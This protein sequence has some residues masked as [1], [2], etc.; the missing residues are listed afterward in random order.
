M[1]LLHQPSSW[2]SLEDDL[3]GHWSLDEGQGL[4]AADT[5]GFG[6]G[7]ALIKGPIWIK[8]RVGSSSIS[9]DGKDDVL[10]LDKD[11]SLSY[12]FSISVWMRADG[13]GVVSLS[14]PLSAAPYFNLGL[15]QGSVFMGFRPDTGTDNTQIT[16]PAPLEE[17]IHI[18]G[19]FASNTDKKLY[20]NGNLMATSQASKGF[21]AQATVFSIGR[22]RVISP[23]YMKGVV[24]EIRLYQRVLSEDEI[25]ELYQNPE[26]NPD[27]P[28]INIVSPTKSSAWPVPTNLT[29]TTNLLNPKN[30]AITK[31]E[32]FDGTTKIGEDTTA[33]YS[34]Q[35]NDVPE[36]AH[37]LTVKISSNDFISTS[38]AINIVVGKAIYKVSKDASGNFS[39]IQECL[40][41]AKAGTSCLVAPGH[42]VESLSFNPGMEGQLV[43]L[44]AEHPY[45]PLHPENSSIVEGGITLKNFTGL[46]GLEVL[47][48][49]VTVDGDSTEVVGNFIHGSGDISAGVGISFTKANPYHSNVLIKNNHIYQ[50][51]YGMLIYCGHDCLIEF[52]DIERLYTKLSCRPSGACEG[53]N[54]HVRIFGNGIIFRGNHIHGSRLDEID[55]DSHVDGI[56]S[57]TN[58]G[59][60]GQ[61]RDTLTNII[62]EN[63]LIQDAH[64][65]IWWT[66][67]TSSFNGV[68]MMSSNIIIRNNIFRNTWGTSARMAIGG[69]YADEIYV[70]NNVFGQ[71]VRIT[72]KN[73]SVIKNNVFFGNFMN[74]ANDRFYWPQLNYEMDRNIL[75]TANSWL[76]D[77]TIKAYPALV[78]SKQLIVGP[79]ETKTFINSAAG[80]YHLKTGS[81]AIDQGVDM[82]S[83]GSA[84]DKD[85]FNRGQAWDIGAYEYRDIMGDVSDD[86]RVTLHDAA[87]VFRYTMGAA[88]TDVQKAKADINGDGSVDTLDAISIARKALGL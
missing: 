30:V 50:V 4:I 72:A 5:S 76:N 55:E 37:F 24:D 22:N 81:L 84:L 16:A 79:D 18:V 48:A 29:V 13:N 66:S 85:D 62:I 44:E 69:T 38:P 3:I 67:D 75:Y 88:L 60:G 14:S 12:P 56:Q 34:Y 43:K 31:A 19:V 53:D 59:L 49:G 2:A 35:W 58:G 36:G 1:F 42:Y 15:S 45:D 40:N 23:S 32:F 7:A 10:A 6:N 87:M 57:F 8:G 17:W 51:N 33:P 68:P 70:Y 65:T 11:L 61:G 54:D 83:Y 47:N 71:S 73:R 52:N 20:A 86:G 25:K 26:Q 80:D 41:A 64:Q 27:Q 77:G 21:N 63:N 82:S 39:T 74:T 28:R 46:Y 9:L 78:A